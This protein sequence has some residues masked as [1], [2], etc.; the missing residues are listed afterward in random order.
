QKGPR[1]DVGFSSVSGGGG[2]RARAHWGARFF[3]FPSEHIH[4]QTSRMRGKGHG[5]HV[6]PV[7]TVDHLNHDGLRARHGRL[8]PR[9]RPGNERNGDA[10][11]RSEEHTS[12]LQS[13]ENL[14]CRLLLEKKK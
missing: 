1:L 8:L 12:E 14:V 6:A 9:D 7:G 13:R 5:V 3:F 11:V 4:M 2:R 10:T